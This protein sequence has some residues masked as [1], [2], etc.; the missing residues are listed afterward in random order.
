MSDAN[1]TIRIGC[2]AAFWGDT[3][4]AAAQLVRQGNIDYLVADYLAEITMSIM[5]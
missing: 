5:A 2:S 3:E 1:K 4:T